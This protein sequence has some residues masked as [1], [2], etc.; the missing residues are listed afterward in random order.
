MLQ[1][2]FIY[3][4]PTERTITKSN[5][6]IV[7]EDAVRVEKTQNKINYTHNIWKTLITIDNSKLFHQKTKPTEIGSIINDIDL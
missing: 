3:L 2:Y 7:A 4:K 1:I 6:T 5:S